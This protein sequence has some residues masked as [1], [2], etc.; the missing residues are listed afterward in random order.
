M[1][2]YTKEEKTH[3]IEKSKVAIKLTSL[4]HYAIEQLYK[5]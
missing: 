4:P 5:I 3:I 1:D 2:D